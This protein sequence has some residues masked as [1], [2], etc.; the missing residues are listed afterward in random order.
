[1]PWLYMVIPTVFWPR[2]KS[3]GEAMEKFND[4]LKNNLKLTL[5]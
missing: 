1:M 4:K 2:I 5:P 3:L